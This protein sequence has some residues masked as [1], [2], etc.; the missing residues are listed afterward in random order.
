MIRVQTYNMTEATNIALCGLVE[1]YE[2]FAG[3]E[4]LPSGQDW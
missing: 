1:K 2:F 4:I 3:D